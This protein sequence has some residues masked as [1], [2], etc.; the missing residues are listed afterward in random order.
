[1][2]FLEG[3]A[4]IFASVALEFN[5]KHVCENEKN[6]KICSLPTQGPENVRSFSMPEVTCDKP[7]LRQGAHPLSEQHSGGPQT[8]R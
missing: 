7:D 8:P 6:P 3:R 5:S 1:M 2:D 4:R